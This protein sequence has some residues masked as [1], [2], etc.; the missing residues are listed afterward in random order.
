M[1]KA[2]RIL[3]S[4]A[5]LPIYWIASPIDSASA[6]TVG[7]NA[8]TTTV[9]SSTGVVV[10]ASGNYCYIAFTATGSNAFTVPVGVTTVDALL[11]AGGGAGGSYAFGGGGGAGEVALSA[12]YSATS[13]A[14]VSIFVGSGGT[15]NGNTSGSTSTSGTNSWVGTSTT[16]AAAGGGSGASYSR[17]GSNGGSGGG[18]SESTLGGIGGSSIKSTFGTATRYGN[19][20]G[21]TRAAN[22]QA[23]G[24]GGGAGAA[25][26]IN[27]GYGAPGPGG[28]GTNAVSSW[29][30]GIRNGMSAVTGWESATATGYIAAGGGGGSNGVAGVGG[31]GGGGNGGKTGN[32]NG[33]AGIA[34]TGSGGGGAAF[35]GSGGYGGAGG[36]G[37]IVIRFSSNIVRLSNYAAAF[38]CNWNTNMNYAILIQ[39]GT[40]STITQL[41][42]QFEANALDSTF[43]DLRIK[44]YS[45]NAGV[46]GT[47]VGTLY[48]G[49]LAAA[50]IPAGG[51]VNTRVGIFT[52][53][54][55]VTSGTRYWIE[56]VGTGSPIS[57][58]S[59]SAMTVQANSW[60]TVVDGNGYYQTHYNNN[61]FSYPGDWLIF[62][63]TT[64]NPDAVAPV[65]TG[66]NSTVGSSATVNT[67]ENTIWSN[68]YTANE[69]VQWSITGPDSAT[70]TITQSGVLTLSGKNYE[71]RSDANLNGVFEVTVRATD[72]ATNI[73]TQSL[74]VII[75]DDSEF[76]IISNNGGAATSST[77]AAENQTAVITFTGTDEDAGTTLGWYFADNSFDASKF[78]LDPNTGVLTFKVAPNFE[79]PTDSNGDN[80]YKV[81]IGLFDGAYLVSQM[82]SVTV[83]DVA[84]NSTINKPTVSGPIYKGVA[85]TI[86]VVGNL[87]G[88]IRF[89]ID[90]KKIAACQSVST[91]GSAPTVS[92]SCTFKPA[93]QG[94]H[95]ITATLTPSTNGISASTSSQ[96]TIAVGRRTGLR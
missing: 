2:L 73:S 21:A 61:Y 47:L 15:S 10:V 71:V 14:A 17:T 5:L 44:I 56:V 27:T 95:F 64:G 89:F 66:P 22:D 68:T 20:G 43:N 28:S 29:L 76:P 37:L 50:V 45:N 13:A 35:S 25:G 87:A 11:I 59:A 94:V 4:L 46:I 57:A 38:G 9:T 48:P 78:N 93:V 90:G 92:A 34:N 32:F 40:S 8:C 74:S 41:R 62:E 19:A 33:I 69:W 55:S 52:G 31:T 58:C 80:V 91:T 83:T 42:M 26:G 67:Y 81:N 54:V 65:I 30:T 3:L 12:G 16:L 85:V 84:E 24:G 75:D 70:F 72:A 7:T 18:G 79:V 51:S 6:A 53:S 96:L 60:S 39:A 49:S 23:G 88:K 77:T 1:A 36:S 82:L 63:L 86:T